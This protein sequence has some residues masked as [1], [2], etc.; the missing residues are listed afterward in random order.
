MERITPVDIEN[1]RL[2]RGLFGYRR[3]GADELIQKATSSLDTSLQEAETLRRELAEARRELDGYHARENTLKDALLLAQKAADETR[4][5]AH[6]Q[7]ENIVENARQVAL[8]E[9]MALQQQVSELRWD[10]ERNREDKRRFE[11][12]FQDLLGRYRREA[13]ETPPLGMVA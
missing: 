8:A 7:A 2:R 13:S 10:I 4:A 11:A 5:A 3:A 1:T 9:R 6:K 12:E